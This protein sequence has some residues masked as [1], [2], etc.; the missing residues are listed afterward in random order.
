MILF[1]S[2]YT[3]VYIL[4][5]QSMVVF[6]N[7]YSFL[8]G[9]STRRLLLSGAAINMDTVIMEIIQKICYRGHFLDG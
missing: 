3:A 4:L 7:A 6:A 5:D 9:A 2:A 1:G 8:N